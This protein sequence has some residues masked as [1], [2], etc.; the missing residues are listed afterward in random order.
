[1]LISSI[2]KSGTTPGQKK[3]GPEDLS[4]VPQQ[5]EE[6]EPSVAACG[7][8]AQKNTEDGQTGTQKEKRCVE[9]KD[10]QGGGALLTKYAGNDLKV[11]VM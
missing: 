6:P 10:A 8:V 1:M 4:L 2:R 11:R 5:S 9:K 3:E 7:W